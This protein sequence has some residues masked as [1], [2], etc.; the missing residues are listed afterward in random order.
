[1][2]EAGTKHL[3]NIKLS[4]LLLPQFGTK[5]D[6]I[7]K[8]NIKFKAIYQN[9]ILEL[10]LGK[11]RHTR[12]DLPNKGR[13]IVLI[14]HTLFLNISRIVRKGNRTAVSQTTSTSRISYNGMVKV[15][16]FLFGFLIRFGTR[17][18]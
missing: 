6:T 16:Y 12:P 5:R 4:A 8:K 15:N 9:H 1:M 3:P 18:K 7:G 13:N 2:T 17:S 14:N 10:I 11:L